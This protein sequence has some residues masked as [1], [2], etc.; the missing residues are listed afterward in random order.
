MRVVSWT[1][2]FAA[3]SALAYTGLR[4]FLDGGWPDVDRN[5]VSGSV[6]SAENGAKAS[7]PARGDMTTQDSTGCTSKANDA[8]P[9]E[10]DPKTR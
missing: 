3:V 5:Q 7:Q 8:K 9:H 6:V 4:P 1:V 10:C 2:V